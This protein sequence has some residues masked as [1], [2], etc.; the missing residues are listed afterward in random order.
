MNQ[1]ILKEIKELIDEVM[2]SKTK[3]DSKNRIGRLE[4]MVLGVRSDLN[5]YLYEKLEEIVGY[6]KEASGQVEDKDYRISIANQSWHVF[7][8]EIEDL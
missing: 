3:I 7:V 6:A 1:N 4:F 8:N 2:Y 5:G